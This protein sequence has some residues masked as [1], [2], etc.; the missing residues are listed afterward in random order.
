MVFSADTILGS[1]DRTYKSFEAPI[2]NNNSLFIE[3]LQLLV[4]ENIQFQISMNNS[5]INSI[6]ESI[7]ATDILKS[8]IKKIDFKKIITNILKKF[9]EILDKLGKEVEVF[10]ATLVNQ[11]TVIK[12]YKKDLQNF[13]KEVYFSDRRY[14]Y[15]N[16]GM[17]TSYTTYKSELNKEYSALILNLT[18]LSKFKTYEGLYNIIEKITNDCDTTQSNIEQI[19]GEVLGSFEPIKAEDFP[20]KAFNYFRNGGIEIGESKLLP[21][22]IRKACDEFF[23]YSKNIKRLQKDKSDMKAESQRIQKEINNLKLEDFIKDNLP[24]QANN[25]FAE[26]LNNKC[27][28]IKALCDIYLQL[29]SIKLDA[30]KES[31]NKNAKILFEACKVIIREGEK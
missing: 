3:T 27:I 11:N 19:C 14:I 20:K 8:L 22:E 29:F 10:F 18:E 12:H 23:N 15:T 2:A 28:R 16:L 25:Y 13:E 5:K 7:N 1:L 4:Q 17:N 26:L 24:P 31:H 30:L 6:S 9:I 21:E